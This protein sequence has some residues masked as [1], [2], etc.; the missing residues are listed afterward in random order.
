M[1]WPFKRKSFSYFVTF[2]TGNDS[3]RTIK[4]FRLI[5]SNESPKDAINWVI[6][7]IEGEIG[8]KIIITQFYIVK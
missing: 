5:A 4:G 2:E 7:K 8:V 3:G 1:I 6:E